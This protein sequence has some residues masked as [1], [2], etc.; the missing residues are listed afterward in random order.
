[1]FFPSDEEHPRFIW[2][3]LE[4]KHTIADYL[5]PKFHYIKLSPSDANPYIIHLSDAEADSYNTA[6]F[7]YK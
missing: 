6:V 5:P 3:D 2:V 1:M 7:D 4:R